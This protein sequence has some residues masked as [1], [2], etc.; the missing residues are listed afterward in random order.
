MT[1]EEYDVR[2]KYLAAKAK[3]Q[4]GTLNLQD[5][6]E[7]HEGLIRQLQDQVINLMERVAELED[8][9]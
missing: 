6:V 7:L 9:Q 1:A 3:R 5:V 8:K 4:G 2:V